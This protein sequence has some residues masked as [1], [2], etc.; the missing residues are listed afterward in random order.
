M[1]MSV[2]QLLHPDA[3]NPKSA[4]DCITEQQ[5]KETEGIPQPCTAILNAIQGTKASCNLIYI[6]SFMTMHAI[7]VMATQKARARGYI[8]ITE[9]LSFHLTCDFTQF[10]SCEQFQF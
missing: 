7:Q 5:D 2:R 1:K 9:L 6:T 4:A 8:D 3:L 10:N